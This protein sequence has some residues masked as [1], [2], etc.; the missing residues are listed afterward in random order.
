ML[1]ALPQILRD[2]K[3]APWPAHTRLFLETL[4][5]D[6]AGGLVEITSTPANGTA[7]SRSRLFDDL[8][9]AA[10]YAVKINRTP[11]VNAYVG[12]ALRRTDCAR[13]KRATDGD[14][15]TA[16]AVWCDIDDGEAARSYL[17]KC[18]GLHPTIVVTTGTVPGLRRQLWWRLAEPCADPAA[19]QKACAGIARALGGDPSVVNPGRVMRLPGCVA[20]P[21][22]PGRVW[23]QVGVTQPRGAP[24]HIEVLLRQFPVAP[25]VRVV[26]GGNRPKAPAAVLDELL[27]GPVAEGARNRAV[28]RLVG[29]LLRRGTAAA[30]VTRLAHKFNR[31]RCT[32]PLA[33]AEVD[34]TL[35]S[36]KR[37]ELARRKR[38]LCRLEGARA[39]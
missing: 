4:F 11:G 30:E 29:A 8:D 37:R 27:S 14:F 9:E 32:P 1:D 34:R 5:G 7:L 35:L 23:E 15:L 6:H 13:D 38:G 31:E 17:A 39:L 20:W 33:E 25:E 18:S 22:K 26:A 19:V 36:I 28:T 2:A 10:E 24:H 16:T 12:A 21:K 3:P